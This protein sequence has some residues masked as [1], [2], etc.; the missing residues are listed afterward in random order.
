[1]YNNIQITQFKVNSS[2]H[3]KQ[4]YFHLVAFIRHRY[5]KV[6]Y[7]RMCMNIMCDI[8]SLQFLACF[9]II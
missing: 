8:L 7:I 6:G 9:T 2:S 4:V 1:M 5:G 3:G